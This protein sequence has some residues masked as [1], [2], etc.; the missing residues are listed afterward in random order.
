MHTILTPAADII[1]DVIEKIAASE[2]VVAG[3]MHGAIVADICRV[4]MASIADGSIP[5]P[6]SDF[7]TEFKWSD[8]AHGIDI[9]H[10]N[11]ISI[12]TIDQQTRIT[13]HQQILIHLDAVPFEIL[14]ITNFSYPK[15]AL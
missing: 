13:S 11:S 1:R 9:G 12:S 10:I 8:W 5:P 3:A 6:E 15:I 14:R 7:L 4:L 2:L